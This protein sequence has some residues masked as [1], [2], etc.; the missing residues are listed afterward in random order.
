MSQT[1]VIVGGGLTAA[2]AV[3][4]LREGGFE[5]HLVLFGAEHHLPYERPPLSKGYLLGKDPRDNAFVHPSTWYGEQGIDLRT[6]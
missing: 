3:E 5:G 4:G 1:F 2:K 6:G